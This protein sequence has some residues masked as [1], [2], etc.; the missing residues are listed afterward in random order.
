MLFH[1]N[2]VPPTGVKEIYEHRPYHD[3][4]PLLGNI[5][6]IFADAKCCARRAASIQIPPGERPV[7]KSGGVLEQ[8]KTIHTPNS[9]VRPFFSPPD[10][11][12]ASLTWCDTSIARA[13][14]RGVQVF[15]VVYKV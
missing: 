13:S 7:R 14:I 6:P 8:N 2:A 3:L 5:D 4:D 10:I 9:A 11:T 15:G 1:V 12:F